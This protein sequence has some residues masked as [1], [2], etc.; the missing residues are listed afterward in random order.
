MRRLRLLSILLLA[1]AFTSCDSAG[2]N[3]GDNGGDEESPTHNV[4][5]DVSPSEGGSVSP[6]D[7]TVEEGEVV[8]IKANSSESHSFS[9]WG[10]NVDNED[11]NPFSLTV[12]QDYSL[13]ANFDRKSYQLKTDT[14]GE[15]SVTEEV[16]E[17][18]SKDYEHGTVV[19]LVANP[20]EDWKFVEWKGDITT[21]E[22]PAEITIESPKEVTAVFERK[23]YALNVGTDG[24]GA[25]L[26]RVVEEKSSTY[27]AGTVVKL[28]AGPAEGWVFDEWSGPESI[29]GSTENPVEVTVDEEKTVTAHFTRKTYVLSASA[30]GEGE[31]TKSPDQQEYKYNETVELQANAD[32]GYQFKKWKGDI[33]STE[34][35]TSVTVNA[36]KSVTAVFEKAKYDLNVKTEGEGSVTEEKL[37]N[38]SYEHG[39]RV[40]L[41]AEPA[42]DWVF[43]RW[44][45]DLTGSENPKEIT[46]DQPKE[47]TAVFSEPK[48]SLVNVSS[49]TLQGTAGSSVS[50]EVR[51]VDQV[52]NGISDVSISYTVTEGKGTL[53][54]TRVQ[55]DA[56][57]YASS[58]LQLPDGMTSTTVKTEVSGS[59]YSVEE[60][61]VVFEAETTTALD[62][63]LSNHERI[64]ERITWRAD[65]S[66][67]GKEWVSY[68]HWPTQLKDKLNK[69]YA[70]VVNGNVRTDEYPP[71][72]QYEQPYNSS[73]PTFLKPEDAKRLYL[74][75]ISQSIAVE[76]NGVVSWSVLSDEYS[77]KDLRVLF[78]ARVMLDDEY[79]VSSSRKKKGDESYSYF[80]DPGYGRVMPSHPKIAM[81]FFRDENILGNTRRET[82]RRIV[83]WSAANM[84]HYS[85]RFSDQQ[86]IIDHWGYRGAVPIDRVIDGTDYRG[87]G[88]TKI[89]HFTA[90]CHGT[91]DFYTSVLRNLNIPVRY[92]RK[93]GHTTPHFTVDDLYLTHGDDPYNAMYARK[94]A[95]NPKK[96]LI[97][98]QTWED[99]FVNS[100]DDEIGNNIGRRATELGL[101]NLSYYLL[102]QYCEDQERGRSKEN[103]DVYEALERYYTLQEL[104]DRNLWD[105]MDEK[106]NQIGGCEN[107]DRER[108]SFY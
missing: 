90:G 95:L 76:R 38:K 48:I 26:E 102:E 27:D 21:S 87:D 17:K 91:N 92:V 97:S 85:G 79:R 64:A 32:E 14:E 16:L 22:N 103:G 31:V 106:L 104:K 52:D 66:G 47:V 39:T 58:T 53:S 88:E 73:Y 56:D 55:T 24:E 68:K 94:P 51:A 40:R 28:T 72:N 81:E 108:P 62:Q 84:V 8:E 61:S 105:K 1:V 30:E 59:S 74:M 75:N 12:D 37:Q 71:K 107:V 25:V 33:S 82:I 50:I 80:V 5:V 98:R 34:N 41:T 15:G 35:P 11:S 13:S 7:T 4:S 70:K 36:D 46:I 93:A 49:K 77:K 23:E 101:E 3:P 63:W 18:K 2:T 42:Q 43:E 6:V 78:D 57:G 19:E 54:T 96:L 65:I 44:K 99:W 10:G 89:E 45:G 29:D 86:N 83:D 60:G 67:T 9:H 100:S 69:I 20:S